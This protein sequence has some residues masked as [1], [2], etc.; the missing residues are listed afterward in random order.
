MR[1]RHHRTSATF[2]CGCSQS[3]RAEHMPTASTSRTTVGNCGAIPFLIVRPEGRTEDLIG[4]P[5]AQCH[6]AMRDHFARRTANP[7][8]A[9][10]HSLPECCQSRPCRNVRNEPIALLLRAVGPANID[11]REFNRC[12]SRRREGDQTAIHAPWR[13]SDENRTV[14][15]EKHLTDPRGK[16]LDSGRKIINSFPT[17]R[18]LSVATPLTRLAVDT[19]FNE[20]S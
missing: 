18:E 2:L 1:A 17:V 5:M 6:S 9:R 3:A 14:R 7:F 12:A 8:R 19:L 16:R 20:D 11:T 10:R 4:R 13:S 15:R